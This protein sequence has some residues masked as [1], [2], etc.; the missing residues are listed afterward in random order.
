M[1]SSYDYALPE[2]QIAQSPDPH[3]DH[4]RLLV[5]NRRSGALSHAH[6]ADLG[7]FLPPRSLL[8]ANNVQVMPARL[9]GTRPSG[10]KTEFLL[11]TPLAEINATPQTAQHTAPQ[12]VLQPNLQ[13][14]RETARQN[15][16]SP[17]APIVPQTA[18]QN[19]TPPAAFIVPQTAR[20]NGTS[21]AA[22]IAAQTAHPTPSQIGPQIS[23]PCSAPVLGLARPVSRLRPG[24][25]ISFAPDFYF[26][27]AAI[28]EFGQVRGTLHWTGSLAD[29]L[30]KHG[31]WPLP[32]YIRRP[33]TP[34]DGQRYQTIYAH[35]QKSGAIAAPTAGLHFTAALRAQL[36]AQ[37]HAWHELTLYVGYGTFSAVR[38]NDI[39]SHHMHSELI[40]IPAPTADALREAKAEGR[41]IVAVGTTS[42]RALE[43]MYQH[44]AGIEPFK[45]ETDIFIYPGF[46][47]KLVDHLIT[48]FHL[49][50]STLLM[51][52]AAMTGRE[53]MLAAYAEAVTQGYRFFSYGDAMFIV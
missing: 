15:G 5:L 1:L 7:R 6:F 29:L 10:G 18:R 2:A 48:N 50:G 34:E 17:A 40:D 33:D 19:G 39:R 37:G 36:Q 52:T 47:F 32:P 26:Q 20:Q 43:G 27:L 21:P 16:R 53:T 51:L 3:R 28:G 31:H 13:T 24:E 45:G 38:C 23:G 42:A 4:S 8:I 25:I 11:L 30:T 9:H 35:P 46:K 44:C 22:S 14:D 41:P 12:T 49:P